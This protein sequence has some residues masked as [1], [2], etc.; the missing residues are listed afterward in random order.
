MK[1][2]YH[3]ILEKQYYLIHRL[4]ESNR[5]GFVLEGWCAQGNLWALQTRIGKRQ[6]LGLRRDY[7][8]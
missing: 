4:E 1:Q 5:A 3:V 7:V 6:G 8:T 2:A